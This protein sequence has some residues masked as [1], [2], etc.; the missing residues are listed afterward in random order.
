[1]ICPMEPSS[2]PTDLRLRV[3]YYHS[4]LLL[5]PHDWKSRHTEL[6]TLIDQLNDEGTP[7]LAKKLRLKNTVIPSLTLERDN[8]IAQITSLQEDHNETTEL[9]H[10]QINDLSEQLEIANSTANYINTQLLVERKTIQ[11]LNQAMT[12][13]ATNTHTAPCQKPANIFDPPKFS[14]KREDLELL[15]NMV[16]IKLTGNTEQFPSDQH[17]LE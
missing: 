3:R 13:M 14:G 11:T 9:L 16:N 8:A 17:R 7:I 6:L 1:M 4:H 12:M 10:G 15:K 2:I 5:S